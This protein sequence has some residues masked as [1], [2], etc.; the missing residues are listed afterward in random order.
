MKNKKIRMGIVGLGGIA[1]AVHIPGIQNSK[2]GIVS[3]LCD[4]DPEK[5]KEMS[6]KYSV[7]EERCFTSFTDMMDSGLV[8]AVS[9]CT[10]NNAHIPV[11]MAALDRGMPFACEKP[12]AAEAD[13]ANAFLQAYEKRP[14]PAMVCFSYRYKSA[15]RYARELVQ[16]GAL[17]KIRHIY[18]QYFQAWGEK[19][20]LIWRFIKSVAGSGAL[21]DLGCHLLDLVRFITGRQYVSVSGQ[22]GRFIDERPLPDGNGKGRSD[23]DDYCNILAKMEGEIPA[24]FQITRFAYGRGNYQRIEIYGEKGALIYD[25][26]DEDRLRLYHADIQDRSK[27]FQSE[28]IPERFKVDQMQSFLNLVNGESDGLDATIAEGAAISMLMQ[29]AIDSDN[30]GLRYKLD[31]T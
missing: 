17:G 13:A 24:V 27:A 7:A 15:A 25:L 9:I 23:V 29:A 28:A 3:A 19:A 22:L 2:N 31:K 10:P 26:E 12:I 4:V 8:D 11:A 20:P 6:E 16:G 21:G 18:A 1:N 5:L 30:S 14:V